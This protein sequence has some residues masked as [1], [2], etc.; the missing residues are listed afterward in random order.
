MS[1]MKSSDVGVLIERTLV[2]AAG[3]AINLS[4][5]TSVRLDTQDDNDV[6]RSLTGALSG[7]GTDGKARYVTVFGDFLPGHYQCQFVVKIG[8]TVFRS[9]RFHISVDEAIIVTN[10]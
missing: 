1:N 9:D 7:S 2:D 8:T 4:G 5:A 10:P 3:V 6:T